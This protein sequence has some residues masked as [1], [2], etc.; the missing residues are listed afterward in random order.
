MI[1]ANKKFKKNKSEESNDSLEFLFGL[2]IKIDEELKAFNK[3]AARSEANFSFSPNFARESVLPKKVKRQI[4]LSK[5]ILA[6][7][8]RKIVK[9]AKKFY[10]HISKVVDSYHRQFDS[11]LKK[12][13]KKL[14]V[15]RR[16]TFS[17]Y[18]KN[19]PI[20]QPQERRGFWHWEYIQSLF[21]FIAVLILLVTPFKLLSYFHIFNF[22]NLENTVLA[23]TKSAVSNLALAGSS[24]AKLDINSAQNNFSSASDDF[25]QASAE[26]SQ[27]SDVLLKLASLSNDPKLK[28]AAESKHF[29]SAGWRVSRLGGELSQSLSGLD[30]KEGTDWIKLLDNFLANGELALQDARGLK[31][32]LQKINI[33]N[34]P[35]EYQTQF[36]SL[37]QE[38]DKLPDNLAFM[39]DNTRRLRAFLGADEDKRYLL[40]FQNNAEMRGSGGFLGSY[41]LVDFKQGKIKNLEVPGGGSYDTE[42]GMMVKIKAPEPLQLVNPRWYFWDANWWPDWPTTAQNLMWFYEKSDGPTV[43]GV[44]SFTPSVIESLL[45]ISGP[46]DLTK[47]YGVIITSENFWQEVQLITERDNIVKNNPQAVAHLPVGEKTKPKKIIG[48][49]MAKMMEI[50]PQKLDKNNLVKLIGLTEQNLLSKQIMFYFKDETLQQAIA[51]YHFDG[52]IAPAPQDYLMVVNTNIAGAKTDK[53]I[54]EEISHETSVGHDGT[55]FDTVTIK[56]THTA[57]KNTPLVGVRNVNWLRVYVPQGS[58]LLAFSGVST[59]DAKY[60]EKPGTDWLDNDFL[61]SHEGLATTDPR[62][63]T[64]IYEENGKTVFANWTMLDPG[65][66]SIVTLR[67]RLPFNLWQVSSKND[68]ASRLDNWLSAGD[69]NFYP[70]SLLVQKQPGSVNQSF[71]TNLLIPESYTKLWHSSEAGSDGETL[72][73]DK[74]FSDLI[75]HK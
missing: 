56:R 64:K 13:E 16:Q 52:A 35:P 28:L 32:E 12:S 22:R 41:A 57:L 27:I 70:Y 58:D 39:L 7:Q 8:E 50:L 55:M 54:K 63:G 2:K 3:R 40:V 9:P 65:E 31:D 29:L 1:F 4:K 75:S 15:W 48:D 59:P 5:K 49:L 43:D 60:F 71:K 37:S 23:K 46:I 42:A 24:V 14:K 74:F 45:V 53:V 10:H 36:L 33:K 62:T 26:M 72:N 17:T 38:I 73:K 19:K 25:L 30:N 44:I 21:T 67:Y 20:D 6:K 34:L 47:D 18:L 66:T 68:F 51:E 11:A 69:V 61:A